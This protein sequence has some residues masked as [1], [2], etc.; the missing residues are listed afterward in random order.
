MRKFVLE[1]PETV[2]K[3][4]TDSWHLFDTASELATLARPF[5][6][7]EAANNEGRDSWS[8][9][10]FLQCVKWASAGRPDLVEASDAYMAQFESLNVLAPRARIIDDVSGAVPNIPAYLAG[11]PLNMRRRIKVESEVAPLIVVVDGAT[12][13][14]IPA[15][16]MTRRAS[17]LLALV[18]IVGA[19]RP[20]ELWAGFGGG[21]HNVQSVGCYTFARVETSPLDVARAAFML[22]HPSFTRGLAYNVAAGY[23]PHEYDYKWPYCGVALSPEKFKAV[24]AQ[25]FPHGEVF[26]TP[27]LYLT[28]PCVTNPVAWLKRT[29]TDLNVLSEEN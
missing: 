10:T 7:K 8:G 9:G 11:V 26:A 6:H 16:L 2:H 13:G 25:A 20:V 18:R 22:G 5:R 24:C 28:D 15:D 3:G 4:G 29:L 19:V 27:G 23:E 14:G 1:T 21:S 17:V 12:S